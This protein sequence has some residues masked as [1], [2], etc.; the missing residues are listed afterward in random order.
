L[1]ETDQPLT[2]FVATQTPRSGFHPK[3]S[4]CGARVAVRTPRKGRTHERFRT[5]SIVPGR[6]RLH[7]RVLP[8]GESFGFSSMQTTPI[9]LCS[10]PRAASAIAWISLGLSSLEHPEKSPSR[11][12]SK[13]RC[14]RPMYATYDFEN[15]TR[16]LGSRILHSRR[17]AFHDAETSLRPNR[18]GFGRGVFA[19]T[20]S[21]RSSL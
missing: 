9:R 8:R 12:L 20:S 15:C 19:L 4:I 11:A 3:R 5:P 16:A 10:C 7:V 21:P 14:V 6:S 18:S 2:F 17:S 13:A 1:I